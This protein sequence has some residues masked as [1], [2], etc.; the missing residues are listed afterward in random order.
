[1]MAAPVLCQ[2]SG[3]GTGKASHPVVKNKPQPEWPKSI[4]KKVD[5]TIVLRAVFRSDGKVT[6]IH[7]VEARPSEPDVF[8][9]A[10]IQ[11]IVDRAI[12]AANKITFK[13]A[14][15]DGR[16]VSM[17]MELEYNFAIDNKK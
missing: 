11:A 1:M 2:S 8:S 9:E 12:E 6:N 14:T 3:N 16:P 17:W 13:P 4:K 7:F 10:E 5:C 15:K